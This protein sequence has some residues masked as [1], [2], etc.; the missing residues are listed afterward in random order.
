M[1][2]NESAIVIGFPRWTQKIT[3]DADGATAAANYP[4]SNLGSLPV[5]HVWR[6]A[7][8]A[9]ANTKFAGTFDKERGVRLIGLVGHNLSLTALVRVRL[10]SDTGL[11]TVVYDSGWIDVWPAIYPY[12]TLEWEDDRW[13]TGQYTAEEITGY[14]WTR[15]F[16]LDR[17]YLC[18]GFRVE[19]ND[20]TNSDGYVQCGL[21][22]MAQ[23]W[24]ASASVS[25]GAQLGFR[26][27]SLSAEAI[28]G[29]KDHER[30]DKPRVLRGEI[31]LMPHDEAM[32]YAFE[33]QRQLDEDIPFLVLLD[34]T[35]LSIRESFLAKNV[36]PGL[37]TL[38]TGDADRVPI[39][40]EEV[41]G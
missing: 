35:T 32:A 2:N 16:W 33:Q 38:A 11:T 36:Q 9:T 24:Q 6:S 17:L 1:A 37:I 19:F 29:G 3:F 13:W 25:L 4:V 31:N 15:P 10:Y 27:R 23:G 34:P 26:F 30:R 5:S 12:G 20:T 7:S 21:C 18:R 41:L 40:F 28:G 22:E 8:A 39:S 14:R